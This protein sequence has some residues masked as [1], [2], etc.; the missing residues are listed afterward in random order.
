MVLATVGA[1]I[2]AL[3]A[4][5][6]VCS[7][8]LIAALLK[9]KDRP[10]APYDGAP[11]WWSKILLLFSGVRVVVHNR[12]RIADA[13]P[14]IIVA[15]H[16]SWFDIPAIASI[17]KR[18]RFVSK[19]EV[20][21]VPVFGA[22]MHAVGMVPIQREN[23]K[24]AFGAYSEAT[25]RIQAG[26][27]VVVFPEGSRGYDYPLRPFKKGPFVFAIDAGVPVIPV[28]IHGTREVMGKGASLVRPGRV[29]VHL[30]EPVSVEGLDFEGRDMLA[31]R[32]RARIA[33]ALFT[34][35]GIESPPQNSASGMETAAQ[36][37]SPTNNSIE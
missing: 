14:C 26:K 1:F 2:G 20:F 22:A 15:N 4:T 18:G 17:L 11:R 35:Y 24:A 33:D 37:G 36:A 7:V 27:S 30:L 34:H 12:E 29:D 19:A 5:L 25:K 13:A 28:L 3:L 16:V 23:R 32:V 9:V 6:T 8:C 10:Y 21:R 31:I